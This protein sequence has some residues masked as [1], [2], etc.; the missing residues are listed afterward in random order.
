MG[1][2]VKGMVVKNSYFMQR[3]YSSFE[4][5]QGLLQAGN[6]VSGHDENRYE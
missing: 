1:E 5:Y 2:G 3:G 4:G 6:L